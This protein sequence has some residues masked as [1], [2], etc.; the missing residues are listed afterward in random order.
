MF[1]EFCHL[2]LSKNIIIRSKMNNDKRSV[3]I[4]QYGKM[5]KK[6]F[7]GG[8]DAAMKRIL[9]PLY[10]LKGLTSSVL[11]YPLTTAFLVAAAIILA[12]MIHEEVDY[13]K[14]LFTCVVGAFLGAAFQAAYE[15]F[16]EKVFTR[17]LLLIIAAL[18][19]GGY[20]LIIQ[21][22]VE[23]G[24]EIMIRTIVALFA[25]LIAFIWVPVIR[26][27]ITF[28]ESFMAVF[29]AIFQSYFFAAV[30][31]AGLSLIVFAINVLIYELDS[32]TFLHIA[33]IV[34]V[35]FAPIYFLSLIPVYPGKQD[36]GVNHEKIEKAIHCPK[37]LDV[38]LSYIIIPIT[39]VFTLILI[40][41]IV[42]NITGEFWTNNL[43]ESMIV[44]YAIAVILIYILVSH[45]D[46][47]FAKFFRLIFPKV[48]IPIVV[49]QIISV[50]INM[51]NTGL[52]FTRYY[53]ILFGIFAAISGLV[54]SFV[55]VRKNGIIAALLIVFS[56]ISVI[57][58]VDAF[59]VSRVSME[60]MLETV[61]TE[62][63]M[64]DNNT[65]KPKANL[66]EADK[67]KIIF[68]VEYLSSMNYTKDISYF[69]KDF[70][71]YSDFRRTFGFDF[72]ENSVI[73]KQPVYV[74]Y[75]LRQ[76]LPITGFDVLFRGDIN[77]NDPSKEKQSWEFT[78]SGQ[79]YT[80]TKEATDGHYYLILKDSSGQEIIR[81]TLDDIFNRYS[82]YDQTKSLLTY[83]EALFNVENEKGRISVIVQNASVEFVNDENRGFAEY[84]I[85]V[86]IK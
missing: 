47:K 18:L 46:N 80:L 64:L 4:G 51:M 5:K 65:I 32:K 58:P 70:N 49:L 83:E 28:N 22:A 53:E 41:Y 19:T 77:F 36:R 55:S 44:T 42:M 11:R 66:A 75:D 68:A 74:S 16:F 67:Q 29:K 17:I 15:R 52:P 33:N 20:Y 86:Q 50:V 21:S 85:L 26:S 43:L 57:P 27:K 71:M 45:L 6:P 40:I 59:T 12:I 23:I 35:L 13:N 14:Y 9:G 54:M 81:F 34:F 7:L 72:D 8:K 63:G 1:R 30:I 37:F 60:N 56:L 39:A 48:L 24:P 25:V 3:R 10:S 79:V 84:Y 61:L 38:L 69:P 31:F 76:P 73:P 2:H 62:N 82:Q 78:K